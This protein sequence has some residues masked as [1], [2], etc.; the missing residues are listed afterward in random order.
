MS[1][2]LWR[3]VAL[4]CDWCEHC[5]CL[6]FDRGW[7]VVG[8]DTT[9]LTMPACV[10]KS[11]C[12]RLVDMAGETLAAFDKSESLP[13]TAESLRKTMEHVEREQTVGEA[14]SALRGEEQTAWREYAKRVAK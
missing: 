12:A 6:Q 4:D 5:G 14:F 7:Q 1:E 3:K 11:A 13:L 2:H 9:T 10:E 8:G